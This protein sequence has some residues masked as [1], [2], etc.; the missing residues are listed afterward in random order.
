MSSRVVSRGGEAAGGLPDDG[1][2]SPRDVELIRR[3][4]A[5]GFTLLV[6]AVAQRLQVAT[7]GAVQQAAAPLD[8]SDFVLRNGGWPRDETVATEPGDRGH[9]AGRSRRSLRE[10]QGVS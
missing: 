4:E 1:S 3:L 10:R 7:S 2:M 6:T 5:H 8:S 9:H